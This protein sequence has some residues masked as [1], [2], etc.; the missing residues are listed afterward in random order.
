[1]QK[2]STVVVGIITEEPQMDRGTTDEEHIAWFQSRTR[3]EKL[4]LNDRIL[5]EETQTDF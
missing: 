3:D 1:M 2:Q 5:A 4:D